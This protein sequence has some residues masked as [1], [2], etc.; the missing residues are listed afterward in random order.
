MALGA[1]GNNFL[2]ARSANNQ[3]TSF[4]PGDYGSECFCSHRHVRCV[5]C[6]GQTFSTWVTHRV[7]CRGL[8]LFLYLFLRRSRIPFIIKRRE[9]GVEL[10]ATRKYFFQMRDRQLLPLENPVVSYTLLRTTYGFYFGVHS[11]W[12]HLQC[13]CSAQLELGPRGGF[14]CPRNLRCCCSGSAHTS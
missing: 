11:I 4:L 7:G 6:F 5:G 12:I 1:V 14:K 10:P 8:Q 9:I 2:D 13:D 3:G